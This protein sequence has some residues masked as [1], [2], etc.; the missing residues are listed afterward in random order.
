MPSDLHEWVISSV[1]KEIQNQLE[2]LGAGL[3]TSAAFARK[4]ES[5]GSPTLDFTKEECG[6]H[7]PDA[8]FRHE[9]AQYPGVV[10][11]VSYTQK[12][13]DLA[14]I[15]EDYILGSN[16]DIR[17][18]IGLDVEYS[19]SK[20]ATLSVWRPSIVKNKDGEPELVAKQ[21]VIDQVCAD[22]GF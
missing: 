13:K 6:R 20:K 2:K 16:G 7:T 14:Y 8:Q 15:A 1:V 10:I 5:R 11:E 19:N 18:V 21:T 9:R 22:R 17:V 3:N 4:V 12:R